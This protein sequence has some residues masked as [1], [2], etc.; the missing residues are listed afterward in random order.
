MTY[1]LVI[2]EAAAQELRAVYDYIADRAGPDIAWTYI[3]GV[4]EFLA[5]LV[6]FPERGTVHTGDL[7]GLRIIGYRRRMSIAF[8][9][10]GQSVMVVGF[11][12]AGRQI[13]PEPLA[14]RVRSD[15]PGSP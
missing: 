1:R 5:R 14:E 9:I 6:D 3:E 4:R 10:R 12:Y 15:D 13:L 7:Q 8:T 11:H 2:H